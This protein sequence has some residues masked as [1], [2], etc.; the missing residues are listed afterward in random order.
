MIV[1]YVVAVNAQILYISLDRRYLEVEFVFVY[2]TLN[3]VT[4]LYTVG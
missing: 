3:D 1:S 2:G 4:S